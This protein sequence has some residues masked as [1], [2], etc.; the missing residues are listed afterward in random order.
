MRIWTIAAAIFALG[1]C[2]TASAAE[3]RIL[4]HFCAKAGCP[5]GQLPMAALTLDGA[6]NLYGTTSLGGSNNAGAVFEIDRTGDTPV[7]HRLFNFQTCDGCG[8]GTNPQASI[9]LDTSGAIYGTAYYGGTRGGGT[10]F[11]L[12]PIDGT[13]HW[14]A[15]VYHNFCSSSFCADGYNP[16]SGAFY[17]QSRYGAPYDGNSW[18]YG[19]TIAGGQSPYGVLYRW[20]PK[21]GEHIAKSFCVEAACA[22]GAQPN[23]EV[24]FNDAG[25]ACGTTRTGGAQQKGTFYCLEDG[26]ASWTYSFCRLTDCVDG[27]T[28]Q[29]GVVP[30]GNNNLLGTTRFGGRYNQGTVFVISSVSHKETLRYSFCRLTSCL[31]GKNPVSSVLLIGDAIYGTTLGGGKFGGGTIYRIDSTGHETVLY[32]FCRLS[33]C[34]DGY[35][36]QAGLVTDGNGHLFGTASGGGRYGAG[37]VFELD[38]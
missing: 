27:S 18:T 8:S 29:A 5:D 19:V 16:V 14:H 37:T 12:M 4:R 9:M 2:S 24:A 10:L 38:L 6:G 13:T 35:L 1:V 25:Y 33:A 20:S 7:Y 31:D 22:D 26:D 23:G 34:T 15:H 21:G 30:D 36:P 11:K 28:P 17:A 32:S 3:Y